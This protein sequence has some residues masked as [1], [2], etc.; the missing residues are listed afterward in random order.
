MFDLRQ[1]DRGREVPLTIVATP[2]LFAIFTRNG[3]REFVGPN[4]L[5]TD[6]QFTIGFQIADVGPRFALL[7][8][9]FVNVVEVR[10][11][12]KIAVKRKIAGNFSLANPVDQLPKQYAVILERFAGRFA[13]VAFLEAA[14]LQ[15]VVFAV[16]ANVVG[17]QVVVGDLVPLLGMVPAAWSQNQ[18]TSLI[19]FPS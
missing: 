2:Q 14:E 4:A 18:P 9:L 1:T 6:F 19:S 16:G 5:A 15:R 17:K 7:I 12:G 11:A 10:R 8:L 3:C 13:L